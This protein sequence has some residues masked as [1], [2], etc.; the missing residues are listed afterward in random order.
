MGDLPE[1]D[2]YFTKIIKLEEVQTE[3]QSACDGSESSRGGTV[4]CPQSR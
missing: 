4:Q 1:S 3:R 2:V